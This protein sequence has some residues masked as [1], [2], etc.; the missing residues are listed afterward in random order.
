MVPPKRAHLLGHQ[1]DDLVEQELRPIGAEP[2]CDRGRVGHVREKRGN[3]P[4]LAGRR[5]HAAV[6]RR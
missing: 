3:N 4:P 2:L 5:R 1:P 6:I